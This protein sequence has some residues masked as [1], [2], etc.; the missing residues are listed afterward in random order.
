MWTICL[1]RTPVWALPWL[2]RTPPN[3]N[4]S[5]TLLIPLT[6]LPLKKASKPCNSI[7]KT[8]KLWDKSPENRHTIAS[9]EELDYVR[10]RGLLE[11]SCMG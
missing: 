5:S 10:H 11:T 7:S 3:M 1:V 4:D 2:Q 9:G 6:C 8:T